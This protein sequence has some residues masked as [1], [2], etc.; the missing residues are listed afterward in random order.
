MKQSE[1]YWKIFTM[2]GSPEYYSK[3]RAAAREEGS[4]TD[5]RLSR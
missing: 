5:D 3:Y 4:E 2:T 1:E